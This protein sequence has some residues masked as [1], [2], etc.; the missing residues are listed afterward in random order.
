MAGG[1][2]KN[3]TMSKKAKILVEVGT[4][5][6]RKDIAGRQPIHRAAWQGNMGM[7]ASLVKARASV[8]CVDNNGWQPYIM[9]LTVV[10]SE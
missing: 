9:Q 10:T 5:V 1:T 3:V 7:V 6:N 8:N 2:C 4:D